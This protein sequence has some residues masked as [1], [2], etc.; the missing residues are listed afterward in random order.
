MPHGNCPLPTAADGRA[1]IL[2]TVPVGLKTIKSFARPD[3]YNPSSLQVSSPFPAGPAAA[4]PD[5]CSS[6]P[7]PHSEPQLMSSEP[8]PPAEEEG[9]G[10][11]GLSPL[12]RNKMR[13]ERRNSHK[14][15]QKYP[16]TAQMFGLIM[17]A[18]G[19]DHR[20]VRRTCGRPG[21]RST[22]TCKSYPPPHPG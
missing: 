9:G 14:L 16:Q 1:K 8:L 13:T 11:K 12:C 6:I 18:F 5:G 20:E 7:N 22:P 3:N 17:T 15:A 21:S 2:F 10:G 4:R 19:S